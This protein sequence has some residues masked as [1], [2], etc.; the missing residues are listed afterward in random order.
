MSMENYIEAK[1]RLTSFE[2]SAIK[3]TFIE[4]FWSG[5]IYLFGS[6]TDDTL[7]GGDID[8]YIQSDNKDNLLEKK[9]DFL[10]SLKQKIGDQ[11]IDVIISKDISRAIEKEALAKGV[12]L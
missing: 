8:I 12:L 7:K 11:K 4:V 5:K 9:L 3:E 10:S 6:R 2:M 1:I